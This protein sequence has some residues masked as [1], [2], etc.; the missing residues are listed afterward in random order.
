ME[1]SEYCDELQTRNTQRESIGNV[2]KENCQVGNVSKE[3]CQVGNV[4]KENCQV[5]NVSKENCQV[6]NVSKENCQ[7]GNVSKENCQVGNV[8]KEKCQI[9]NVSKEICQI[10]NVSNRECS[11]GNMSIRGPPTY[12]SAD[13]GNDEVIEMC[14][15]N[16]TEGA[17]T[18]AGRGMSTENRLVPTVSEDIPVRLFS[19][20]KA[21]CG[22]NEDLRREIKGK[23]LDD[24]VRISSEQRENILKEIKSNPNR[25][26]SR[27]L[28]E[29]ITEKRIAKQPRYT[30]E[31]NRFSGQGNRDLGK[32]CAPLRVNRDNERSEVAR[33]LTVFPMQ[34]VS[35]QLLTRRDNLAH[36]LACDCVVNTPIGQQLVDLELISLDVIREQNPTVG[37]IVI[38]NIEESE[39]NQKIFTLFTR[40]GH[41]DL[42]SEETLAECL[43]KLKETIIM[44]K[45]IKIYV[46][47]LKK[48]KEKGNEEF[49]A[50]RGLNALQFS[51]GL[52]YWLYDVTS[53]KE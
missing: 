32:G 7:V 22:K 48:N 3:N 49:G 42:T 33:I 17:G 34:Y 44:D 38:T 20:R 53:G 2:S 31:V 18:N 13:G 52:T 19:V 4:S 8:S 24:E 1:G 9:G 15:D 12:S 40:E 30:S 37:T 11:S 21:N 23:I 47:G 41:K 27:S 36:F 25:K 45:I 26:R 43:E 46:I 14:S 51:W 5:G 28:S 50:K 29:I 16:T 39:Y 6:G 35:E 10:G